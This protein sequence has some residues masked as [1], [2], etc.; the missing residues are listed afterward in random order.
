MEHAS[1]CGSG[2]CNVLLTRLDS[3]SRFAIFHRE[4]ANGTKSNIGFFP[5]ISINWRGKPLTCLETIIELISHTQ[6][7]QGLHVQAVKDCNT[8][9]T[10]IKVSDAEMDALR[11]TK[12][13][14]HG[15]WNYTIKPQE[16]S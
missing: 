15:E 6:T 5:Y 13:A 9:P 7:S 2:N 3:A 10:G 16:A 8:Y 14:F 4:Q 12:E 11:I 1:A